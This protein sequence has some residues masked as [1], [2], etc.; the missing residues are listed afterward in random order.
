MAEV[1][2]IAAL[3]EGLHAAQA[4]EKTHTLARGEDLVRPG[5]TDQRIYWVESGLVHAY[6]PQ[7]DQLQ[8]IRLGY[9]GNLIGALDAHFLN[10]PTAYG[11]QALRK[12][13]LR[14]LSKTSWE[15]FLHSDPQW[16]P[17]WLRVMEL[18]VVQQMDR[19]RDLLADNP[20]ARYQRVLARSPQLFQQ[21]PHKYI[22]SYLRMAPE[23]LS[24]IKK[25]SQ[26]KG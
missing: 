16:M 24:R 9:T 13:Q 20:E 22:A 6:L 23:T 14:S 2:P 8:T 3:L 5:Q 11:I 15:Q 1:N 25:A 26:E 21:V 17:H 7:E 12:T 19:E 4:W 10:Q 18:L